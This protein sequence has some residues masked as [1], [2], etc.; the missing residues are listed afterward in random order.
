MKNEYS[1]RV[2]CKNCG[3]AP[4]APVYISKGTSIKV[5]LRTKRCD[6]CGCVGCLVKI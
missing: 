3:H 2:G 5:Y 4:S 6:N 1:I